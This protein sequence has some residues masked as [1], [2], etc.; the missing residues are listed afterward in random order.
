MSSAAS[1]AGSAS[2]V[3]VCRPTHSHV[4]AAQSLHLGPLQSTLSILFFLAHCILSVAAIMST[5]T[6]ITVPSTLDVTS[7]TSKIGPRATPLQAFS[8]SATDAVSVHRPDTRPG[9]D[10]DPDNWPDMRPPLWIIAF[11]K[12]TLLLR[13]VGQLKSHA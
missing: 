8:S 2:P 12:S 7:T 1:S 11:H 13:A 9:S 10:T 6:D 5:I 4:A 3:R